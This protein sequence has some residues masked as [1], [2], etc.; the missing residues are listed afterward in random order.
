MY[1]YLEYLQLDDSCLIAFTFRAQLEY[2]LLPLFSR[3][4]HD[5][6]T[7]FVIHSN[8]IAIQ[9]L[10]L[11]IVITHNRSSLRHSTQDTAARIIPGTPITPIPINDHLRVLI[12]FPFVFNHSRSV[13]HVTTGNSTHRLALC[14]LR[15]VAHFRHIDACGQEYP[16]RFV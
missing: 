1:L 6:Q 12:R 2:L 14:R 10:R 8:A 5:C 15:A 3:Y 9:L 4:C 11:L 16:A 7:V 13:H